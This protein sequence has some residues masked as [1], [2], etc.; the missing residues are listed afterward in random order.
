[1]TRLKLLIAYDG[2][3][4]KGWQSQAGGST[5]QDHLEAAFEKIC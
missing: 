5:V 2:R 3:L 4:F 1:M